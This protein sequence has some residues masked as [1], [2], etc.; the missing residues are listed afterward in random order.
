MKDLS[1]IDRL[2]SVYKVLSNPTRLC[3]L[4]QLIKKG[5]INVTNLV[6]CSHKSQSYVS[7]ELAK[8]KKWGIV[9]N[10]RIGLESFYKL[11]D[12]DISKII[13]TTCNFKSKG[14]FIL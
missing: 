13:Q 8:L 6:N 1:K 11:V 5:Q 10:K 12:K 9:E 4:C 7:Q 2:A 3:I 14:D